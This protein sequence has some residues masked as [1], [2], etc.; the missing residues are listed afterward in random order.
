MSR[1]LGEQFRKDKRIKQAKDLLRDALGEYRNQVQF[2]QQPYPDLRKQYDQWLQQINTLRGRPLYFPYLG[3]GLGRGILVELADGS[4]K[5]D[6]ITGIGV[7]YFGH[8]NPRIIEACLDAALEDIVIQGHLQLNRISLEV[9]EKFMRL[10][11]RKDGRLEHCFLSTS[12]AMA[13]ENAFKII[14]HK[15]HPAH[16]L[17]AFHR[18]FAGRS[19]ATAQMTDKTENREGIPKVLDI[20]YLPFFDPNHPKESTKKAM[21]QLIGYLQ[22]NKGQYAG[23]CFELIQG[24]GGC[25]PG[26]RDFFVSLMQILKEHKVAVM[27]DEIQTFGRTPQP[28]AFQH[29]DLDSFLDVVTVGKL[30]QV[31]ATLFTDEYN[32]KPAIL[33]QTFAAAT[34]TLYVGRFILDELSRGDYF[35]KEG[36]I[37]QYS[38]HFIHHLENLAKNFPDKVKGPFGFGAMVGFTYADGSSEKAK[39]FLLKLFD[40]GV[41]G[42]VSGKDPYRIRFLIPVGAVTLKNIDQACGIIEMTLKGGIEMFLVRPVK[43]EDLDGLYKLAAQAKAGLT[44]LPYDKELLRNRVEESVHSFSRKPRKPGPQVYLFAL[45]DTDTKKLIGTGAVFSKIGGFQPSYTYEIKTEVKKSKVLNVEKEFKY[46]QLK[47]DYNGPSEVGTLFLS[48]SYR[49]KGVG[50]LLSL[51]RFLFMAQYPQ[52]FEEIVISEMRGVLDDQDRSPFWNAV[53]KHFFVVDF[54]KADL[55][56]MRDKTFIEDLIPEHPIYI[57]IL[58]KE[59]QDVLGQVHT[60]TKPALELLKQ[61]GFQVINEVDIFEAGPVVAAKVKEVRTVRESREVVVEDVLDFVKGENYFMASF[62]AFENFC[63][64]TGPCAVE[65]QKV[66][67]TK[68]VAKCLGVGKGS[69]LRIVSPKGKS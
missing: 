17:L 15:K 5:Y 69:K 46:L 60:D 26:E 30:T 16:R 9:M 21:D 63:V 1:T 6:F 13:N 22:K 53:C 44:T 14:F 27:V 54:K 12:G 28:F 56:V 66:K 33:S 20:D 23:M 38:K 31:C 49:N 29:F 19:L 39:Q 40:A 2:R 43:M 7:H 42:F 59:A 47:K 34:S 35:G 67:I 8:S 45:E 65:G 41:I 62:N 25:Y 61:E 68:D 36:K 64:T 24:E 3:S 37:M 48:S 4:V 58:P 51:S 57:P 32:P 10:A 52:C 50:R 18:C 11:K 55:M